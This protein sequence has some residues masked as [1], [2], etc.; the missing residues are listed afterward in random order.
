MRNRKLW[1]RTNNQSVQTC[2]E[3]DCCTST[4]ASSSDQSHSPDSSGASPSSLYDLDAKPSA[5]PFASK[6]RTTI[7]RPCKQFVVSDSHCPYACP[8]EALA[9]FS[10]C[11]T[12][13]EVYWLQALCCIVCPHPLFFFSTSVG[14]YIGTN[15]TLITVDYP[16]LRTFC[17]AAVSMQN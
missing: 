17:C 2:S 14:T 1:V 5:T 16:T 9:H 6:C 13:M 8:E 7:K 12:V 15:S 10:V 4:S 11:V 3:F